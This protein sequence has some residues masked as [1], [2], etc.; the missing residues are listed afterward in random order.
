[1]NHLETLNKEQHEAVL[2]TKGALLVLA[3]AGAGKTKTI[4]HRILHL[5]EG[6]VD[7]RRVLAITFTN[8]AASEMK[9]RVNKLL[10]EDTNI[11][12]PVFLNERPFVSTF[13]ALS[14]HILRA[15]AKNIGIPRDFSIFDRSDSKR[16]IKAGIEAAGLNPKEYEPNVIL[17]IIGRE[18]SN[19]ISL[20]VFEERVHDYMGEIVLSV[21]KHYE[22]ALAKEKAL[23]FD[24]LLLRTALLLRDNQEA[25][26]KWGSMWS[27]VHV[28]EYQDTN[29]VQY[30]IMKSLVEKTG[31]ICVVGDVDQNI[32]SWRGADIKNILNFE[33]DFPGAKTVLLEE[34]YRSTSV[35]LD[36]ANTIIKKNKN[37]FEKNL[38]TKTLGGDKVVMYEAY[39]ENDEARYI[40]LKSKELIEKGM[41]AHNI[42]VLYRANFQSR[43][44]EEAFI[45]EDVPYQ[46]LGTRFFERKEVRDILAYMRASLNPDSLSDIDRII[47]VP[48]RGIGKATIAKI[49][50]GKENE[51]G[52]AYLNKWKQF[53]EMLSKISSVIEK[54]KPSEVVKYIIEETGLAKALREGT[55]EEMERLEN[56]GELATLAI[57]YDSMPQGEGA[58]KMLED[59]ALESD[60]DELKEE[61]SSVRLMTVHASKG[62]EFDSVFIAGLEQDLFPHKGSSSDKKGRDNEEERRLFYVAVTRAKRKLFTSY[63]QIRT[64]FGSRQMTAPSEFIFDIPEEHVQKEE[65]FEGRGKVIYLEI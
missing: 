34:N 61:R 11:N 55:E 58:R 9:E 28:D 40:A 20:K 36:V 42:A 17:S 53:K 50:L 14:V 60:Q 12:R 49:F 15:E 16:V 22:Q 21:W 13:H 32:Y 35:I 31:N 8:K 29:R 5:I 65:G 57:K 64:I 48:A 33:R 23:D 59:A 56:M 1:V 62:L 44:L 10:S 4:S 43:A 39:D 19:G 51:L 6:G 27:Y 37:R 38:F 3:G 7:P 41:L 18:K 52:P 25:K 47:N 63:A 26:D 24:D 30:M 54:E 46:V 45:S 2:H